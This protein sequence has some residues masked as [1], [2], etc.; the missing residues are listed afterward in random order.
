[1]HMVGAENNKQS[2]PLPE[3]KFH[4]LSDLSYYFITRIVCF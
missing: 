3:A 2:F 1:M 4:H